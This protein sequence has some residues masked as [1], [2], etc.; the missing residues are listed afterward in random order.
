M[1]EGGNH[2]LQGSELCGTVVQN[3]W[4]MKLRVL[5]TFYVAHVHTFSNSLPAVNTQSLC[6]AFTP[7]PS[8][9]V[10]CLVQP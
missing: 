9:A 3:E 8:A 4:R 6:I 2:L 1:E 7:L 10:V 5:C